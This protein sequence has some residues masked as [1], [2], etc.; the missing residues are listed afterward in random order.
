VSPLTHAQKVSIVHSVNAQFQRFNIEQSYTINKLD[1][2]IGNSL[3][4]WR[5]KEKGRKPQCW[6]PKTGAPSQPSACRTDVTPGGM[7]AAAVRAAPISAVDILS[8]F[9]CT[10]GGPPGYVGHHSGSAALDV[11]HVDCGYGDVAHAQHW[12]VERPPEVQAKR[13][14]LANDRLATAPPVVQGTL[15]TAAPDPR[16][17]CPRVVVISDDG[18]QTCST[19][20]FDSED[21]W[22]QVACEQQHLVRHYNASEMQTLLHPQPT[23]Q[24]AR[25]QFIQPDGHHRANGMLPQRGAN[26]PTAHAHL[27][28]DAPPRGPGG[29]PNVKPLHTHATG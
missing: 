13:Q 16:A 18:Q 1:T 25:D 21:L 4:R 3:Y 23:G 9:G 20:D 26:L 7:P 5:C 17:S 22:Q 11:V 19:N 10:A 27:F 29:G 6:R 24:H 14:R 12:V 8:G 2:W 28:L 15:I